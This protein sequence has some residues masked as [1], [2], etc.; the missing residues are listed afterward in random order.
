MNR[1][2]NIKNEDIRRSTSTK[3][4]PKKMPVVQFDQVEIIEL[5]I[6]L[7]DSPSVSTGGPPMCVDWT[8]IRRS[9]FPINLYEILVVDRRRDQQ[10]QRCNTRTTTPNNAN[11]S[12][13]K[14]RKGLIISSAGRTN[15]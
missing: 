6:I 14:K 5:P 3:N 13:S 7:G 8:P 4:S 2:I 15:L 10:Q 12:R 9:I 11:N 1:I